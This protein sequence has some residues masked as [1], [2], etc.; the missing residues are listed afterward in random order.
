MMMLIFAAF[1]FDIATP[2]TL[3]HYYYLLLSVII[4]FIFAI[5]IYAI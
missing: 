2:S 1:L 5:I 3:R 4:T